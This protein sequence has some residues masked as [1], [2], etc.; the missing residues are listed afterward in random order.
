MYYS[1]TGLWRTCGWWNSAN[2]IITVANMAKADPDNEEIQSVVRRMFS[3]T[4]VRAPKSNP[5]PGAEDHTFSGSPKYLKTAGTNGDITEY[6][7]G[8][9]EDLGREVEDNRTDAEVQEGVFNTPR[10]GDWL[11]G[12]YDDDLWWA[13]AWISAYDVTSDERYLHLAEDI[14]RRISRTWPTR[15]FDGGIYWAVHEKYVNAI[16]NELFFS[17]AAH[18]A[19]R[20]KARDY[21]TLWAAEALDW[22]LDSGLINHEGTINDGL[23]KNCK[24]N[25]GVSY[26]FRHHHHVESR[27]SAL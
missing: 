2:G 5:Q 17:T 24:N 22:F 19:N 3:E 27:V 18:L 13:L 4:I 11:D 6:S 26:P 20:A 21:Y 10:A 1:R 8:W 12:Y 25:G 15:C 14:W 16:A 7:E 23:D 9:W